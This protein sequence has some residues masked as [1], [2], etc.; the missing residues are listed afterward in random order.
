M[1][2]DFDQAVSDAHLGPTPGDQGQTA[3][4]QSPIAGGHRTESD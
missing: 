3:V 4:D 2:N 1:E